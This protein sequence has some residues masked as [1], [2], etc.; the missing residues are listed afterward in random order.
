MIDVQKNT[1]PE[2]KHHADPKKLRGVTSL[3]PGCEVLVSALVSPN[4]MR[5]RD[6]KPIQPVITPA[7]T[8]DATLKLL[9]R[10][11][12]ELFN[13]VLARRRGEYPAVILE[14]DNK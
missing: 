13:L 7:G 6:T 8:I 12:D 11:F 9:Q 3:L 1:S 4:F 14:L 10:S 5:I 2:E